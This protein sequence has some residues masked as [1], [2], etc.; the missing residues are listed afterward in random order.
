MLFIIS[1]TL[2]TCR[3]QLHTQTHTRSRKETDAYVLAVFLTYTHIDVQTP[4]HSRLT[5]TYMYDHHTWYNIAVGIKSALTSNVSVMHTV[6]P[7]SYIIYKPNHYVKTTRFSV[8]NNMN[9]IQTFCDI[10]TFKCD[11][12]SWSSLRAFRKIDIFFL[13]YF[14]SLKIFSLQA[15]WGRG[16]VEGEGGDNKRI[17]GDTVMEQWMNE[18]T[19]HHEEMILTF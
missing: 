15:M 2:A 5:H 7:N 11:I 1:R 4:T 16:G 3:P 12:W 9:V 6:G 13:V 17:R 8:K 18:S 10:I 19:C 14:I